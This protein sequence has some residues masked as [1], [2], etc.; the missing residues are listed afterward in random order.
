M[1]RWHYE[2]VDQR[3]LH[4]LIGL[5]V[6]LLQVIRDTIDQLG[7]LLVQWSVAHGCVACTY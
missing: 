2:H 1:S 5:L 4:R 7:D 6:E 3:V